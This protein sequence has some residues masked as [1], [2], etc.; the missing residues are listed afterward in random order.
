M[1]TDR[2]PSEERLL[3]LSASG[4]HEFSVY[5]WPGSR[6]PDVPVVCTHGLTRTGRDFD[7]LAEGLSR[8]VFCP[9]IVG[10]GRSEHLTAPDCYTY[11]QYQSDMT[12]L[13]ART[14]ARWIDWVG[15]SMGGLIGMMLAARPGTPIRR[16]V[17]NDI[18]PFISADALRELAK[19]VGQAPNFPDFDA[20]LAYFQRIHVGF[21]RLSEPEWRHIA[22]HALTRTEAGSYR[23]AYDPC[24][25]DP[26]QQPDQLE[27]IVLWDI[28]QRVRCPT[29]ILRGAE[30]RLLTAETARIMSETGHRAELVEIPDTGHAPALMA[31]DQVE[32]VRDWL[33]S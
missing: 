13:I 33:N 9:D 10:R 27:D 15:T 16:L 31:D 25:A 19:Y 3:G 14:G 29:L 12:A 30:S 5:A 28:W 20:A 22:W 2:Q 8:H 24:I 21:G 26:F 7:V 1:L 18:G 32:R 11:A 23:V 6:T 17:L 4:F